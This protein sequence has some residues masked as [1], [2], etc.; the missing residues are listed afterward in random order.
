MTFQPALLVRHEQHPEHIVWDCWRMGLGEEAINRLNLRPS[1]KQK[2]KK[3]QNNN[4][5]KLKRELQ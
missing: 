4:N 1:L 5:K 3:P 2:Q